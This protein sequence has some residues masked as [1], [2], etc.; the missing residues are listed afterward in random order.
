MCKRAS[1]LHGA[2]AALLP[3]LLLLTV[4]SAVPGA[5]TLGLGTPARAAAIAAQDI[6]IGPRGEELPAGS[7]GAVEG[8]AI[9]AAKCAMCHGASGSEGPDPALVG[10]QG[11]LT[12][13]APRLTIG[14]YWSHS[15]TLFDYIRRAMPLTVP[16]SLSA[17]EVYALTALLLAANGIIEEGQRMDREALPKVAMPNRDGFTSDPRPDIP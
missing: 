2:R 4:S 13:V 9:Y 17:D 3:G 1:R 16:G 7:G 5:D 8:R 6:A 14:S 12:G 10:G 11:T 15:T